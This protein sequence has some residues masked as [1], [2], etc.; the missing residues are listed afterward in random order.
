MI[1][2]TASG[3]K[4]SAPAVKSLAESHRRFTV[5]FRVVAVADLSLT[6]LASCVLSLW[7][8]CGTGPIPSLA[9]EGG[10]SPAAA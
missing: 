4:Q 3:D 10:R 6:R 5:E 7:P 1:R 2:R 8:T 9:D